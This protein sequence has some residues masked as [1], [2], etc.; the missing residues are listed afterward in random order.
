MRSARR[1][2][3]PKAVLVTAFSDRHGVYVEA[4]V[5]TENGNAVCVI[6]GSHTSIKKS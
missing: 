4:E 6:D 2:W 5:V 1:R 3:R